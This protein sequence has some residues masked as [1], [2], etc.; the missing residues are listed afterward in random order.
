MVGICQAIPTTGAASLISS[1]NF[2]STA[3]GVTGD[4]AYVIWGQAT[5]IYNFNSGNW[6]GTGGTV[7]VEVVGA[8][9]IGGRTVY[10]KACDSTGCGSELTVAIPS[11][12]PLPVPTYGNAMRDIIH[13]RFAFWNITDKIPEAYT[14][15]GMPVILIWGGIYAA[16]LIGFWLRTRTG[17]MSLFVALL[18]LAFVG[19]AGA[20]L[21]LG[22]PSALFS[23][24]MLGA[25][26]L[27]GIV[28]SLLK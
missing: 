21:Y 6:S 25:A 12:T 11:I 10:Y 16:I 5:G 3:T 4:T 14:Y 20:G 15:T 13:R 19:T 9:L 28:Y 2:T 8:P 24:A 18:T 22:L 17:R 26:A 23:F 27:A 7:D 1:N